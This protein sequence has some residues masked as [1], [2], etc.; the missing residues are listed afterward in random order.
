MDHGRAENRSLCPHR[1]QD[2]DAR[3]S[4][5]GRLLARSCA[6]QQ[7]PDEY[8]RLVSRALTR[9]Q[10]IQRVWN[11]RLSAGLPPLSGTKFGVSFCCLTTESMCPSQGIF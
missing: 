8:H 2:G 6:R 1:T 9:A 10:G 7:N 4:P 11:E 3:L 5:F